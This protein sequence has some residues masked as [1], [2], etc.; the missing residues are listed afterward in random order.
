M[1]RVL[2]ESSAKRDLR[3]LPREVVEW[4]LE[5]I[6]ELE[7]NPFL[8]ERLRLPASLRGVYCF[9]LRRG[10]YR[11]VYCYVPARDTVYIV[12]VGHRD[13]IY[14]RFRRRIG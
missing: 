13:E 12:A 14:E 2:I 4:V 7:E 9:K 6:G 1:P 5:V 10:D 3:R 8:G 11:L